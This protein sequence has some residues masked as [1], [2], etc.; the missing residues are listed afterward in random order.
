MEPIKESNTAIKPEKPRNLGEVIEWTTATKKKIM[1][2]I[3]NNTGIFVGIFIIFVVIVVSTTDIKLLSLFDWTA[4]G[5]SFFV[6]LF[7][8]FSMYVNCFDSGMKGGKASETYI[9]EKEAYEQVRKEV[10]EKKMHGRLLEFC[11]HYIEEELRNTRSA[12]L[13][14]SGIDFEDY[15]SKYVG[16]DKASLEALNTL[17]I[18]QI[19]AIMNANAIKPIVLTP[20]MILKC[21]RGTLARRPLGMQPEK[22]RGFEYAVKFVKTCVTSVLLAVIT[23]EATVQPSWA[24]FGICLLKLLPVVLNGFMGYKDGYENIVVDTVN[25]MQ[26]QTSLMNQLIRYCED[27]P[28]PKSLSEPKTEVIAEVFES[29]ENDVK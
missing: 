15:Q 9:K 21:G 10:V 18:T 7:C 24:M 4:L 23:L 16:K 13:T 6:L 27:Y 8:A 22:K 2:R 19:T 28:T 17:S 11:R 14:E 12:A 3:L 1:R 29:V 26:D 5:L 25:Y 20:E